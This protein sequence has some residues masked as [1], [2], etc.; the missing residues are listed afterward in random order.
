MNSNELFR[1]RMVLDV[2]ETNV[3]L[4]DDDLV[5]K[6]N[7]Y[8]SGLKDASFLL[9]G[10]DLDDEEILELIDDQYLSVNA[11]TIIYEEDYQPWLNDVRPTIKF[12]FYDRYERYLKTIKKWDKDALISIGTT[13]DIILDHMKNPKGGY[14]TCKGLVMGDIQSGKT[15]NYAALINK[16]LDVGYKLIIVLAGTTNDLRKQTQLR[17]DSEVL[18]YE[19][20][21]DATHGASKGVSTIPGNKK[22]VVDCL[23]YNDSKGDFKGTKTSIALFQ[24]MTPM[25]AVVKKNTSVLKH[26]LKFLSSSPV[27]CYT[28]NKLD[29]PVLIIDDEVDQASVNTKNSDDVEDASKINGGIRKIIDKCNRCSY[30]GYTATPFA[31]IFINPFVSQNQLDD[32]FPKNFIICLPTP[33]GY[34][35]IDEF[36]SISDE[37]DTDLSYDLCTFVKDFD[38]FFYDRPNRLTATTCVDTLAQSLIDAIYNFVIAASIKKSRGI[39]GH[40]SMLINIASVK[41]PA[42]TLK[43]LV[44]EEV[45]NLYYEY[46]YENVQDKYKKFWE[47]NIKPISKKRLGVDF[48]DRWANIEPHILNTYSNILND[49]IKLLNGDSKDII[50]YEATS[51]GDW[52]IVGGNKLSRGLTLEGLIISYFY[53]QS[54]QYDTLLQ[55]G[56]WFG[57]RKGWLD[58]CR[59]YADDGVVRDFTNIGIAIHE[60]K[61]D[62]TK[63]NEDADGKTPL[64]FG[65]KIRTSPKL[66]PTA[67]NKMRTS[68]KVYIS[69]AGHPTQTLTFDP[70]DTD[71]NFVLADKFLKNLGNSVVLDNGKII[72][73][74]VSSDKVIDFLRN[75]HEAKT[76]SGTVD[77]ANWANYISKCN[78]NNMMTKWRVVLSSLKKGEGKETTLG[79]YHII[80]ASRKDREAVEKQRPQIFKLKV[81]MNPF[82]FRDAFYDVPEMAGIK[83]YSNSDSTIDSHFT[84]EMGI[85]SI[86]VTDIHYKVPT[87]YKN[88][89]QYYKSGTVIEDGE[90]VVGLSV[91]FPKSKDK[92][93]AVEYFV[94]SVWKAEEEKNNYLLE[95]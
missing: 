10:I 47:D 65:L 82:D 52:I 61:G 17:L 48:A 70:K 43:D 5:T 14:F 41:C 66:I 60:L 12:D 39:I 93:I 90:N 44:V 18:G 50:D 63:M 49:S 38:D 34:S 42:T 23:T 78:E 59:I 89:K 3:I 54:K 80:K 45:K 2:I 8:I 25:I 27:S 75:Y 35:G 36:F 94:N 21:E 68:S 20:R 91:W 62:I 74:D 15:A 86:Q 64:Q 81:N 92:S 9:A 19:T 31:N 67:K 51:T 57:Y 53:R 37:E 95:D 79:G 87:E 24:D 26:L 83:T 11:K 16:S 85:L 55:M 6:R 13:S 4:P 72:F 28:N 76:G 22:L 69:Y 84:D 40:N 88:N 29:V 77:V 73:I 33:K 46:K 58:L 71:Y 7:K 32:L 56:R 1:V 30:V